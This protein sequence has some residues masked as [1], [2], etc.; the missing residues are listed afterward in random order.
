MTKALAAKIKPVLSSIIK[1]DQTAYVNGRFIGESSRLIS[2]II[3]TTHTLNMDGYL[4][5]LDIQKAFDSVDHDFLLLSLEMFGFGENFINWIKIILNGQES[6]VMNGGFST[7]YFKLERGTRQ[8]DPISAYLFLLVIEVFFTMIRENPAIKGL[9]IL[10]FE[11]KLSAYADDATC[12]LANED[13]IVATLQTFD[14][15]SKYSGLSLNKTK[16]EACG[17]GA[18][19]GGDSGTLW[20]E[21]YRFE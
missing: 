21:I 13:S 2:D 9:N 20:F 12:I 7:G 1:N 10:G 6:C 14:I 11:Y 19:R 18:K 17:I 16:C 8:G 4:L 5:T 3:E 15:F